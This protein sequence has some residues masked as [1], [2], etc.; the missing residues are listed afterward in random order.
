MKNK[1][2][3]GCSGFSQGYWKGIFYPENLPSK[4][5]LNFYAQHLFAVEINST[6]YRKPQE[7]TLEKW[8]T[9]TGDEF[10][11]FIKIPKTITHLQ[12]LEKTDE[13]TTV[14]CD[15]ISKGLRQK[16]GGF[17]FQLPPSFRFSSD[18]L[19][20]VL[21][22]VDEKY[23]NVV[24]FR[25]KSWWTK[26]I[27]VKLAEKNIVFSG[28]SIPK[29]IPDALVINNGDFAYYR[30]H[31]VPQLFKSEYSEEMLLKLAGEIKNF[32]GTFYIFFNNTNGVAAIKNALFLNHK[33]RL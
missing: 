2:L 5:Y 8:F 13:L 15:Y 29:D 19:D 27:Q 3:V 4:E 17:L 23:L 18:N 31:G 24:E 33:L 32:N 10:K 25:D 7:K 21:N 26:E 28:V 20:K 22:T 1:I 12:K 16:L 9:E 6:F 30:L 14:F 11:F